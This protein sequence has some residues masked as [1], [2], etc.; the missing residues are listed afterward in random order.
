MGNEQAVPSQLTDREVAQIAACQFYAERF[1]ASGLPGHGLF[2]LVSKLSILLE[3]AVS[4]YGY[5]P[6]KS[7]PVKVQKVA[8]SGPQPGG[9]WRDLI[10]G[11]KVEL[12]D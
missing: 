7:P 1:A 2:I 5:A 10:T 4:R 3:D 12:I 8:W 6:D 9:C 11:V